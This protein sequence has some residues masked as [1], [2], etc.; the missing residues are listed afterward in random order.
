MLV[1][2]LKLFKHFMKNWFPHFVSSF[3]CLFEQILVFILEF[4][5]LKPLP[6]KF[7]FL[8]ITKVSC[9][10]FLVVVFDKCR[11]G[12][13]SLIDFIVFFPIVEDL[14]LIWELLYSC[15][16]FILGRWG[17]LSG[18][19][20]PFSDLYWALICRDCRDRPATFNK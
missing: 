18:W 8:F 1:F 7:H 17:K 11:S 19:H 4:V 13:R 5:I 3:F 12:K 6:V 10:L 15:F 14:C 16:K 2:F 9:S 20:W